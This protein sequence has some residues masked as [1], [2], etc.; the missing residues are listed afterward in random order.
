M[1]GIMDKC[2]KEMAR[3]QDKFIRKCVEE[4]Y[5]EFNFREFMHCPKGYFFKHRLNKK[6]QIS[7][8]TEGMDMLV[9]VYN[10][11]IPYKRLRIKF[12]GGVN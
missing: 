5:P 3:R 9:D 6:I 10:D 4:I 1:L 11:G 7:N 8:R 12:S 2:A